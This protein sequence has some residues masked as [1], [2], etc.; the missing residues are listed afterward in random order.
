MLHSSYDLSDQHLCDR[1]DCDQS[2]TECVGGYRYQ[3]SG[4]LLPVSLMY[5]IAIPYTVQGVCLMLWWIFWQSAP[6]CVYRVAVYIR[7]IAMHQVI[8]A[9]RDPRSTSARSMN[10]VL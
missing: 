8:R 3:C 1:D 10:I 9:F 5:S 6:V 7:D 4:N 2:D